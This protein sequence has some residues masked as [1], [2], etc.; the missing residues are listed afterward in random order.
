MA[1]PLFMCTVLFSSSF[2]CTTKFR[3]SFLDVGVVF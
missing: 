1:T 3:C 2:S